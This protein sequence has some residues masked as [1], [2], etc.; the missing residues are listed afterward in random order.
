[1]EGV[2]TAMAKDKIF[3]HHLANINQLIDT[4]KIDLNISEEKRLEI[5]CLKPRSR[6]YSL[7]EYS[8][9]TLLRSGVNSEQ[10]SNSNILLQDDTLELIN[11]IQK[12]LN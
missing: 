1:M 3:N 10:L 7:S 2:K 12:S 5:N 9:L 4:F 8:A 11:D 6:A